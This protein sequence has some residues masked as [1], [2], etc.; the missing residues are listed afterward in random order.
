[1][2]NASKYFRISRVAG[3]HSKGFTLVELLVVIAIIGVLVALLLPA[4]QAAREAARRASCQNNIRNVA[5]AMM[6]YHSTF[7]KF[8][9]PASSPGPEFRVNPVGTD[10]TLLNT[11]TTDILPYIEQ[12]NLFDRFD[13]RFSPGTG[14]SRMH[15]LVNA[16]L[17][18]TEI[19]LFLCPSDGAQGAR[20]VGGPSGANDRS[21]ARLNY[22]YNA[23]QFLPLKDEFDAVL[24]NKTHVISPFIDFN[25]GIGSYNHGLRIGQITDG[26]TNTIMLAEMRAGL[27]E[28]D[29]RGVWAMSM[30]G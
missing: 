25:M 26:T 1:V 13:I 15:D 4:V 21:W 16:E 2:R 9:A 20:F 12:Q 28:T 23:F 11:W 5:L 17:V 29:R 6:N 27:S 30:C 18:N 7:N 10:N 14:A 8:P 24:G 19:D 3:S 22:G